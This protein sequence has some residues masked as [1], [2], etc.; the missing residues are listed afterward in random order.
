MSSNPTDS[1]EPREQ[2]GKPPREVCTS[3]DK[4]SD[5]RPGCQQH[6]GRYS[7]GAIQAFGH[8][9]RQIPPGG[10]DD[11]GA[12]ASIT[13]QGASMLSLAHWSRQD[14]ST[15]FGY[16]GVNLDADLMS[17]HDRSL[18]MQHA[19][20]AVAA[21]GHS[22]AGCGGRHLDARSSSSAP[23]RPMCGTPPRM[24]MVAGVAPC[25][26]TTASTA[27]AVS[28]FCRRQI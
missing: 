12:S 20:S 19:D 26:R 2:E 13:T 24:A 3:C 5:A 25:W 1:A 22:Q 21:S 11:L 23:V 17:T 4:N 15:A 16:G 7:R 6:G 8:D 14:T 28:R 27:R 10:L 9:Q 18:R